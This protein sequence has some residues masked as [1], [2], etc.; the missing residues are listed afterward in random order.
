MRKKLL[1]IALLL[2]FIYSVG[3]IYFYFFDNK[4][5]EKIININSIEGYEYILKSSATELMKQEFNILKE[6]LESAAV[7]KEDYAVSIAKLFIIDLYTMNNKLNKYD[8]GGSDYIYKNAVANY[9]LSVT[10]TLYKYL[11][12]NDGKRKQ[13]LPEVSSIELVEIT[14]S[15][16]EI[17]G[18]VY[19]GYKVNL[20]WEYIADLE[21]DR[22]AEIIII[23]DLNIL[24]IAEKK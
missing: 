10:D 18:K 23:E 1:I 19:F 3:G 5:Q 20:N 7:N 13:V 22:E 17:D 14:E 21:Y 11:E 4:T 12:D 24:Y 6:N 8:V 2:T 16:L 15:E 9:K